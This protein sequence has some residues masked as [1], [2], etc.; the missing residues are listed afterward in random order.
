MGRLQIAAVAVVG[1]LL[2]VAVGLW[3]F[4][5]VDRFR[6]AVEEALS[7]AL[8]RKVSIGRIRIALFSGGIR[9]DNLLI[10]DDPAFSAEPFVVAKSMT[11]GIGLTP[12]I[13]SR[14]L[15]IESL[16]LEEPQLVLL[17][18]ASGSWNFSTLNTSFSSRTTET[19]SGVSVAIQRVGIARGRIAVR[20]LGARRA[21]D[22]VA[23]DVRRLSNPS[24][25]SFRVTAKTPGAGNV[26]LE[27]EAGPLNAIDAANTPLRATVQINHLDVQATGFID[28]A[29]GVAG[30]ID[31]SGALAFD[32]WTIS[33]H[34]R[35]HASMAQLVPGGSP[36]HVPIE[37]DYESDYNTKTR[38]ASLKYG[39]VHIGRAVAHL[40]GDYFTV[41]ESTAVRLR[42]SGA[43]MPL[44]E[45]EAAMPAIGFTL[46]QEASLRQGMLDA[47]F[48]INGPVDRMAIVGPIR[49][50]NAVVTGFDLAARLGTMASFAGL[51][52]SQRNETIIQTLDATLHVAPEG[53]R[54][55]DVN[56]IVP[57]IGRLTG[58]GTIAPDATVN[59]RMLAQPMGSGAAGVVTGGLVRITSL[60]KGIPFRIRGT[61]ADPDFGPD[62]GRAIGN[63]IK[64]PGTATKAA[65]GV[66]GGLFHTKKQ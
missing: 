38:S 35:V 36:A 44:T 61:T 18:A 11:A 48:T 30:I 1:L 62:V 41:G 34:G 53:S 65:G 9:V 5:D 50:S 19:A 59:F 47:D 31:F 12:L 28:P 13:L 55:D 22:D 37:I 17:R 33:S 42:L 2:A 24:R 54:V 66:L 26:S 10:A 29:S 49:V 4:V 15:R 8:G 64:S 63:V 6:P 3:F 45:F 46:P 57:T 58:G 25:F 27:G 21:Y 32:S 56:L 23:L 7:R 51:A 39:D 43:Q 52:R 40:T 60:G 14:R 20:D 16:R